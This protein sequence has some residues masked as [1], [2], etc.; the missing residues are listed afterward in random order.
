MADYELLTSQ[1]LTMHRMPVTKKR[2]C[3]VDP[4]PIVQD[5]ISNWVSKVVIDTKIFKATRLNQLLAKLRV[6]P[7]WDAIIIELDLPDALGLYGLKK[8]KGVYPDIPIIILTGSNA[9]NVEKCCLENGAAAFIHKGQSSEYI[10]A[11][12]S[13]FFEGELDAR[14]SC[15]L[16]PVIKLTPKQIILMRLIDQGLTNEQIAIQQGCSVHTV[17][18]TA[19]RLFRHTNVK[20]RLQLLDLA[21][22]NQWLL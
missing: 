7:N 4:F 12:L 13:H 6:N 9:L 20:S 16:T 17:K 8:I 15:D 22:R 3:V 1:K 5:V 2:V 18:T 10:Q 21:R 19:Y 14:S 11:A